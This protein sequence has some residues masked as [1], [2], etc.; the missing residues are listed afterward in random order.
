MSFFMFATIFTSSAVK[1]KLINENFLLQEAFNKGVIDRTLFDPP[2]N[3]SSDGFYIPVA[4][5]TGAW[6]NKEN[7]LLWW[8]SDGYWRA[9]APSIGM[10]LGLQTEPN[11]VTF[12]GTDW[13]YAIATGTTNQVFEN[14]ADIEALNAL[15]QM[16]TGD[17]AEVLNS[18]GRGNRSWFIYAVDSWKQ[19]SP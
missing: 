8:N 6:T 18:D 15:T 4:A 12:N 1:E 7:Q 5:A 14:I 2:V 9:I 17:I 11:F 10:K 13:E 3:P 19:F 16:V